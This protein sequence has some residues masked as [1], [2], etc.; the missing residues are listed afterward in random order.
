MEQDVDAPLREILVV[1]VP[2]FS[3]LSLISEEGRLVAWGLESDLLD[4]ML[5]REKKVE[6]WHFEATL[7]YYSHCEKLLDDTVINISYS[8]DPASGDYKCSLE[9]AMFCEDLQIQLPYNSLTPEANES[10]RN[11]GYSFTNIKLPFPKDKVAEKRPEILRRIKE[12]LYN[13]SHGCR[14]VWDFVQK[15]YSLEEIV[16]F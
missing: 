9:A 14:D 10:N 11:R 1:Q 6:K 4:W 2:Y 16:A 12:T 13:S 8:E 5:Q 7:P 15:A 3:D